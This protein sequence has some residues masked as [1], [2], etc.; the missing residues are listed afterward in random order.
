MVWN[1]ASMQSGFYE[2]LYDFDIGKLQISNKPTHFLF[3]S[4]GLFLVMGWELLK[5]HT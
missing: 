4:C 5:L 1:F 3:Y 2:K